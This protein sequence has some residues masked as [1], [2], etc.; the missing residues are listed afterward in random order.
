MEPELCT[1]SCM[2]DWIAAASKCPSGFY[3]K[4]RK[5]CKSPF[6]NICSQ[7]A[8]S[9]V[10][11]VFAQPVTCVLCE[12]VSASKQAHSVHMF[13]KHG[14]KSDFRRYVPCTHCTVC[15]REFG[16]RETCLNHIRYR[17]IVCR[18][19]LLLRGPMLSEVEACLLDDECRARNRALHAAGRRRHHV[20]APSFYLPG[21][22]LPIILAPGQYS[23]HHPLGRGHN[24]T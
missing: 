11:Q 21:P 2:G 5:Y 13:K 6:A 4:V 3:N 20:E 24:Y 9:P 23:A 14:V 10:L 8:V 17:S 1:P 15:L 16:Q 12:R 22:L 18:S 7:W 19:N